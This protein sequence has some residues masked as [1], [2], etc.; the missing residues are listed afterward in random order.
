MDVTLNV[1]Q[2]TQLAV[3]CKDRAETELA[4]V[5]K[6]AAPCDRWNRLFRT[7]A[8]PLGCGQSCRNDTL[9]RLASTIGVIFSG[10]SSVGEGQTG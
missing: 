9:G 3:S 4:P 2:L 7:H 8:I 1:G 6:W 5:G 10:H